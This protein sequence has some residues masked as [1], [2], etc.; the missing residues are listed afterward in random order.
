[1]EDNSK[2]F[3]IHHAQEIFWLVKCLTQMHTHPRTHAYRFF[4]YS[5]QSTE[6]CGKRKEMTNIPQYSHLR[7]KPFT[8][9]DLQVNAIHVQDLAA[10]Y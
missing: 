4:M 7:Y 1:M 9:Y 8:I 10:F 3:T 2:S 5:Q 6:D